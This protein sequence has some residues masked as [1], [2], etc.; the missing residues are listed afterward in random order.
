M[1]ALLCTALVSPPL[2][3]GIDLSTQSVTGVLVD[4]SLK[5]V[6]KPLSINFDAS[7]PEYGTSAG[8]VVKDN[9]VVTT[10]VRL[11]LRALDQLFD[12]L[13][14]TGCLPSVAAIS[15]SGQQHGSVYWSERG[16]EAL[17]AGD[18]TAGGFSDAFPDDAFAVLDSPIWADSSTSAECR[19]I[20]AAV[21]NGAA[22][23]ATLTGSRAYERFTGAQIL[24]V[25]SRSPSA[26]AATAKV[27]LVSHFHTCRARAFH[28]CA[29]LV[30]ADHARALRMTLA[31]VHARVHSCARAYVHADAIRPS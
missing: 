16:I 20:E 11:W 28:T 27:S 4:K 29:L 19:A 2:Y 8:M 23:V 7:F 9:G 1:I 24:A 30:D 13:Q 15:C 12:Q 25:S 17:M 5:I 14:S 22:G 3:L 21:A 31:C 18:A 6:E 26:W 10:P